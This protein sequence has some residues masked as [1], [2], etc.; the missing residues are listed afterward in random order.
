MNSAE[1][2]NEP[3]IANNNKEQQK[4][5]VKTKPKKQRKKISVTNRVVEE[6]EIISGPLLSIE[7]GEGCSIL[8]HNKLMINPGGLIGGRK[9]NDGVTY[10][11]FALSPDESNGSIY[12]DLALNIRIDEKKA[13]TI[14]DFIFIIYILSSRNKEL[15]Y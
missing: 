8:N 7:E 5:I 4:S 3:Q 15:L 1:M 6:G 13:E 11:T 10:F 12:T 9:T 14:D 2:G